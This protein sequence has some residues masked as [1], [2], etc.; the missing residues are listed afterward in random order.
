[1]NIHEKPWNI[2]E[3]SKQIQANPSKSQQIQSERPTRLT[4]L[5]TWQI[6]PRVDKTRLRA[7]ILDGQFLGVSANKLGVIY[8]GGG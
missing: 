8:W 7:H 2:H 5:Q 3:Q 1:M 4:I 6:W